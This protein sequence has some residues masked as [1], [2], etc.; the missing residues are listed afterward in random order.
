MKQQVKNISIEDYNYDLPD[1]QI[2]K[3]P[4]N[5][6]HSSKL[7]VYKNGN[8]HS[9]SYWNVD[10]HLPKDCTLLF[11]ETRVVQARLIFQKNENT[12][13]EVFCLEP[14]AGMDIQQAM[15]SQGNLEFKCLVGGARKWKSTPLF[16]TTQSGTI[17]TAEKGENENGTFTIAFSWN[18][19]Q[20]FADILEEAGKTPLPPYLNRQA[21]AE[22]K[23]TYQ[24]LFAKENGSVAAPTSGLHFSTPL[25]EKLRAKNFEQKHLT[26]HVGAGTF[27]PVSTATIEEHDMHAE[28]FS[29]DLKLLDKLTNNPTVKI[30]AVGTTSMRALESLYW[31]GVLAFE[32]KLNPNHLYVDQWEPYQQRNTVSTHDALFA[33]K[34]WFVS[35]KSNFVQA[36]TSLII[37][38]GYHHKI[39]NGLLTN[40][41]QPKSTLLLLVASLIGDD[42]KKM[43]QFALANQY[44]F[45][46]YGDGCLILKND[47]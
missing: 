46:S 8:L 20:T 16:L 14:L 43:Y 12:F 6:R 42:W 7:L 30:I 29:V 27:K 26:L 32:S 9:D 35:K 38:P 19:D 17:L 18:S 15:Q 34:E 36:K 3:H 4:V 5:P 2:A 13:I 37:A 47:Q 28:E 1:S 45:L 21:T 39:C 33:L 40:F 41:H 25:L 22:D 31:L 24:T 44:R 11:N 23:T 10:E